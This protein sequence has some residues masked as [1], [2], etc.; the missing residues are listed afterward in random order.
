M[1]IYGLLIFSQEK[2]NKL[3]FYT[4]FYILVAESAREEIT[5]LMKMSTASVWSE[6]EAFRKGLINGHVYQAGELVPTYT[7][8]ASKKARLHK[9]FRQLDSNGKELYTLN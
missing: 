3:N 8:D 6:I 4:V 1:A 2:C 7:S 5:L 9:T